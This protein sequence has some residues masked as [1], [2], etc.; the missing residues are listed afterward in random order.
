MT[1]IGVRDVAGTS[2]LAGQMAGMAARPRYEQAAREVPE[3]STVLLDLA[4]I[5]ILTSSYFLASLWAVFWE[6]S[7][8]RDRDI[9]PVIY[10][11]PSDTLKDV[12]IVFETKD[13][14]VLF[15]TGSVDRLAIRRFNLDD[16]LR[17]TLDLVENLGEVTA[18]DLHLRD[19]T[20]GKTAWSNRLA[21]LYYNRILRREKLGRQ[22]VYSTSWRNLNYG[23]RF[24]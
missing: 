17:T 2:T 1:K 15:A 23:S 12:E 24:P 21:T 5:G 16:T 7:L 20:I 22:L 6:S 14:P 19:S 9:Y 4:N 10:N 11:V 3:G 13:V 18:A 8:A